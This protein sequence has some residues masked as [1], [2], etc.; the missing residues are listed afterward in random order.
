MKLIIQ[1]L[2]VFAILGGITACA[3]KSTS[4]IGM[5]EL[6]PNQ[7]QDKLDFKENFMLLTFVADKELVERVKLVEAYEKVAKEKNAKIYYVNLV[8]NNT[9]FI[10]KLGKN[11]VHEG[12]PS[13]TWKLDED[14]LVLIENGKA[15]QALG[16][17]TEKEM[18]QLEEKKETYYD[19]IDYIE[20]EID[21]INNF[22][23]WKG[24]EFTQ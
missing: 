11:Y 19:Q 12:S 10:E 18:L 21:E 17:V 14:G 3:S 15:I 6:Q 20:K 23:K 22:M 5:N 9:D 24:L 7:L 8:D 4:H 13:Q 1:W 16:R 2:V